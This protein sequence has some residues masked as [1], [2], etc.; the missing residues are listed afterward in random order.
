MFFLQ[1]ILKFAIVWL[2]TILDLMRFE[3]ESY[4]DIIAKSTQDWTHVYFCWYEKIFWKYNMCE[5]KIII[6][7][8]MLLQSELDAF[9][10]P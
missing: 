5:N 1:Q 6:P 2:F 8:D 4:D 3:P 10:G 9:K 7:L